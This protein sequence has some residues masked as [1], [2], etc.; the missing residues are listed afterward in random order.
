MIQQIAPQFHQAA[1]GIRDLVQASKQS[2]TTG[3]QGFAQGAQAGRR[4]LCLLVLHRRV[5]AFGVDQEIVGQTV[6]KHGFFLVAEGFIGGQYLLRQRQSRRFTPVF[7]QV[8][9][10][11]Q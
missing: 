2:I 10:G 5:N 6:E 1:G 4:G 8:S 3:L 9:A 11:F 7:H